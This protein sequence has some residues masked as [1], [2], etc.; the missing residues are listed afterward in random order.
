MTTPVTPEELPIPAVDIIREAIAYSQSTPNI[1]SLSK[2]V[3]TVLNDA[4]LLAR[5]AKSRCLIT[6]S[7]AIALRGHGNQQNGKWLDDV[8]MYAI[9]P[10]GFPDLT[11]LVVNKATK[12]PSPEAFDARRSILSKIYVEDVAAE[13]LRCVWFDSYER[14]LGRLELIP[15]SLQLVRLQTDEPAK[16]REISRAVSNAMLRVNN[17]GVERMSLG[18]EYPNSLSRSELIAV[19]I[20]LWERQQ[21]RCALTGTIFEL[22][23]NDD[24]GLQ[25]D[26]VSIDRIDNRLGYSEDNI[27]LVTQFANRARG[28]LS[29][30][31]AR[32]RLVQ[33]N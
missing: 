31:E 24:E 23:G 14:V 20:S 30:S 9:K 16:E 28:T 32:R 6:Y 11:M 25:D 7:N 2:M 21:G 33:F 19:V 29:I 1:R 15:S 18:K 17:Y 22:R 13:Q 27:Q 12:K 3:D 26:R 8:F 5:C 4:I 10:L